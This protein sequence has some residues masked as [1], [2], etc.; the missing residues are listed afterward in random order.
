MNHHR[1]SRDNGYSFSFSD[2]ATKAVQ[3]EIPLNQT[4]VDDKLSKCDVDDTLV[5]SWGIGNSFTLLFKVVNESYELSN[6]VINF[7]A[8][9]ILPDAA[10]K[11]IKFVKYTFLSHFSSSFSF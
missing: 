9:D 10:G 5:V 6:F 8:S 1:Y 4:K 11:T 2:N 3:Y 7:N